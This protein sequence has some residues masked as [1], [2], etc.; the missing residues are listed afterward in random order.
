MQ[1]KDYYETLGV[2]R[3]ASGDNIKRAYRKL[4][5][6]YHPDVS[7][8][9]DCEA[10]F[11]DV[12]EAYEVLKDADKREA[13]DRLGPNWRHGEEF[14]PPPEHEPHFNYQGAGFRDSAEFSDFFSSIFGARAGQQAGHGDGF[15]MRGQDRSTHLTISLSD[16]YQGATRSLAFAVPELDSRG[17]VRQNTK[18]VKVTIP[19]GIAAGQRIRLAG[20]GGPGFNGGPNGDLFLEIEF[21]AHPHF[22]AEG[23][24][25]YLT[26]P[27][28]PWE[29][30]LGTKVVVPTLGGKV[31]LSIPPGSQAGRKLRL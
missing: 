16:S 7:K 1:F 20:Q 24:D 30:A 21:E 4:A 14:S 11:K 25:I 31:E 3:D 27:L 5:R 28:T 17:E 23:H 6:K 13:Y 22:H 15:Q 9:A 12:Q 10:H 19:K 2:S 18:S 8:E 29:A 26:L